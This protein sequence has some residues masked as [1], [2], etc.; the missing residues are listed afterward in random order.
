MPNTKPREH[1]QY[2]IGEQ[3]A[4]FDL[5]GIADDGM[6]YAID[7]VPDTPSRKSL[8]EKSS[9]GHISSHSGTATLK[10]SDIYELNLGTKF[11]KKTF[12]VDDD[13]KWMRGEKDDE[14]IRVWKIDQPSISSPSMNTR[15]TLTTPPRAV[16][17]EPKPVKPTLSHLER[18]KPTAKRGPVNPL[19]SSQRWA[20]PRARKS[21][22][23]RSN[24]NNE[25]TLPI[26]KPGR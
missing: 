6:G 24:E 5:E 8:T 25:P 10:D 21:I 2:S 20:G 15:E 12:D 18:P 23:S 17:T 14:R 3:H 19:N 26:I 11:E 4:W 9:Y 7:F 1:L 22:S 13:D 16:S